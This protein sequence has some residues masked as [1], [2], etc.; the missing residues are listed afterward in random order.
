MTDS[1]LILAGHGSHI[2]PNTAGVVWSYVDRLRALGMAEE[3][4]ACFWKE[5]PAL[6][7]VLDTV[8]ATQIFVVPVFTARGYFT[9]AVI[10]TE[11]ALHGP[12]TRREGKTITLTRP[13]GEHPAMASVVRNIVRVHIDEHELDRADTAVAIIG[14]GTRRNPNSRATTRYQAK[15]LR[16]MNWVGEVVDVYLDDEPE[17]PS[18]YRRTRAANIIALPYFLAPGSHV[19]ID[20]PRALGLSDR[21]A[22]QRVAGRNVYYTGPLSGDESICSAIRELALEAGLP[23]RRNPNADAWGGF[24][25]AGRDSLVK[26]L[27]GRT[28]QNKPLRFG[29]VMITE[30]RVWHCDND[31]GSAPM[32]SAAQLRACLR[33]DPFRPLPTS[34]DLSAGWHVDIDRPAQAQA[35]LETVYP[36]LIADWAAKQREN[37]LAEPLKVTSERQVGMFKGIHNLAAEVIERTVAKVCGACVRQP[38]WRQDEPGSDLPCKAA[39]NYWLSSAAKLGESAI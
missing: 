22:P 39:C 35:V 37:F 29:Q 8:K 12:V 24:P 36:G 7:Q 31:A 20:V 34:A 27:K 19:S 11:M 32:S 38:T 6:H 9:S 33:E 4:T 14:H 16:D 3:I 5:P 21:L 1:A 23:P 17:I 28:N 26:A 13:L 15:V 25:K 10:P 18:I 30:K 2:S